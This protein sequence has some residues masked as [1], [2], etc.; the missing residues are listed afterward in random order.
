MSTSSG[1]VHGPFV[2]VDGIV[3]G[4][5]G[6]GG[7]DLDVPVRRHRGLDPAL[8]ERPGGDGDRAGDERTLALADRFEDEFDT[9]LARTAWYRHMVALVPSNPDAPT[10]ERDDL[11]ADVAILSASESEL[12]RGN[13]AFL[14]AMW[15][16]SRGDFEEMRVQ[17]EAARELAVVGAGNWFAA[18]QACVGAV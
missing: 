13:A 18:L 5:G 7:A 1:S 16:Y 12:E 4:R 3:S 11:R 10:V 14:S 6:T 15:A 9:E 2:T 8:A 17:S